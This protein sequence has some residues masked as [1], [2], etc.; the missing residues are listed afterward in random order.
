MAVGQASGGIKW[1]RF[2]YFLTTFLPQK[3]YGGDRLY[4]EMIEQAILADAVGFDAISIP[5]HHLINLLIIP[6]PLQ[7][8]TKIATLT[9]N[10]EIVISIA[11]LPIRDMRIF[12]GEVVQADILCDHRL[13]L[14]VGRGAFDAE[15]SRLGTPLSQTREKFTES[16]AVLE[17][18]LSR[19]EVSWDG[20]FYKFDALTVMPRPVRPIPIMIASIT[21]DAIYEYARRG[22]DV[23]T[24]PLNSSHAVLLEQVNAFNKGRREGKQ[25]TRPPKLSLQR[26]IYLARDDAEAQRTGRTVYEYYKRFDN[27]FTGPGIVTAGIVEALPRKQTVEEMMDNLL[28]CTKSRMIDSLSTYA[29]AG[30]DEV[31]MSAC[32][33]LP[34]AD[35]LEMIERFANEVM[36]QFSSAPKSMPSERTVAR[37]PG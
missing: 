31:I 17:A 3:D 28:I 36:P 25:S 35:M 26:V 30:I 12:A 27:V 23:Q 5:E 24:T 16:L 4:K 33:G 14:G 34:Q 8:A 2:N 7:M 18:L 37:T 21:P 20:D 10:A 19:E 9:Q 32:F 15:L 13:T 6:S 22:Y 29:D 11:V 1:M